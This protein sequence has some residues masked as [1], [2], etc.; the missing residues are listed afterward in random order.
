M[1][2]PKSTKACCA[3]LFPLAALPITLVSLFM[4][5]VIVSTETSMKLLA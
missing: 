5:P 4:L 3:F 1:E 2:I